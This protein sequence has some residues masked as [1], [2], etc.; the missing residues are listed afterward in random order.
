MLLMVTRKHVNRTNGLLV[1]M[2]DENIDSLMIVEERKSKN[3]WSK[4]RCL[5]SQ[6]RF[7][8]VRE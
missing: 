2:L 6:L 4:T 7:G 1:P 5:P 8:S 3:R